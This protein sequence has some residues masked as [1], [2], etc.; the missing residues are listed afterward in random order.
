MRTRQSLRRSLL[1]RS[2]GQTSSAGPPT[3]L[4]SSLQASRGCS[5]GITKE[6]S[7][8]SGVPI[9][10]KRLEVKPT[11]ELTVDEERAPR[12]L[13]SVRPA[14]EIVQVP[15]ATASKAELEAV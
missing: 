9:P 13:S 7:T 5:F 1:S 3:T 6:H 12:P 8:E 11:A 4:R 14:R 2:T 10:D 15:G